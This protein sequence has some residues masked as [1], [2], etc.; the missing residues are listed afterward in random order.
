MFCTFRLRALGVAVA[1]GVSAPA[2]WAQTAT[3]SA[4]APSHN[5]W[6]APVG[7]PNSAAVGVEPIAASTAAAPHVGVGSNPGAAGMPQ[8][9]TWA[10]ALDA[11]WAR[12]ADSAAAA[13][14]AQLAQSEQAAAQA[15]LS[16][17]HI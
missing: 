9:P 17:I 7:A 8:A 16:L 13:A 2:L 1:L 15:W 6:S 11:A 5:P 3:L 10:Q 12:S 14:A 4:P